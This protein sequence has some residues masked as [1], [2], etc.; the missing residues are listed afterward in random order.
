MADLTPFLKLEL[1]SDELV[2]LTWR[3]LDE[4]FR[5]KS[6]AAALPP[7]S[8]LPGYTR[9]LN[10]PLTARTEWDSNLQI[11]DD[12]FAGL[13]PKRALTF[14]A[15]ETTN[16]NWRKLIAQ[17]ILAGFVPIAEPR[18]DALPLTTE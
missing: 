18:S 13:A 17:A 8:G 6:V 9:T 12:F 10:L 16:R 15:D 5:R 11:Y 14:S 7:S 4:A 1:G 2:N 3:R